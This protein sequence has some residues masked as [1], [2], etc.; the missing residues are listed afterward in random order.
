ML[1]MVHYILMFI[2]IMK[3]VTYGAILRRLS[4]HIKLPQQGLR[5]SPSGNQI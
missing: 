2:I 4:E 3:H 5:H 1:E